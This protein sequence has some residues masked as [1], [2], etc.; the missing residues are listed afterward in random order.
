MA[1]LMPVPPFLTVET[2]YLMIGEDLVSSLDCR[3]HLFIRIT[4]TRPT[5]TLT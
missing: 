5:R 2:G 4:T 3:T 1:S